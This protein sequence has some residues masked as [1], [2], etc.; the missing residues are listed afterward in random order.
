MTT[1]GDVDKFMTLQKHILAMNA[2]LSPAYMQSVATAQTTLD[3]SLLRADINAINNTLYQLC[4][5]MNTVTQFLQHQFG[6]T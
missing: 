5:S 3:L 6:K 4:S 2:Q 1:Q